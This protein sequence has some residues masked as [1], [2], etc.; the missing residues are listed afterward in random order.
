MQEIPSCIVD[1]CV[2]PEV[3]A[4]DTCSPL[5]WID[6]DVALDQDF[7]RML[8]EGGWA[9]TDAVTR[10]DLSGGG[11]T[12]SATDGTRYLAFSVGGTGTLSHFDACVWPAQ[13]S[14]EAACPRS[15]ND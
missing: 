12:G 10:G 11:G 4:D 15:G 5:R 14:E 7:M 3:P 2:W 13:P 8:H 9:I 1:G 6:E